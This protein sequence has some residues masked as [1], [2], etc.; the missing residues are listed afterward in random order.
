[1]SL[2][3]NLVAVL[4]TDAPLVAFI[5]GSFDRPLTVKPGY[6]RRDEIGL[7]ELPIIRVTRPRRVTQK[8]SIRSGQE[9]FT[10]CRLYAG[11]FCED[12]ERATILAIE[13]EDIILAA[14]LT[15]ETGLGTIE[16]FTAVNDEG[17]LPPG[18]FLVIDVTLKTLSTPSTIPQKPYRGEI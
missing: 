1:M 7:D 14:L 9:H 2:L 3:A 15:A 6:R 11:F 10:T 4:E 5:D 13:M 18:H 8:N 12:V 17:A 16:E